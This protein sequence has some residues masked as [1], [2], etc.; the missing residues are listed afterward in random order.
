M[1]LVIMGHRAAP[2]LLQGKARLRPVERLD[3]TFFINGKD[4][5]MGRRRDVEPDDIVQFLGK[6]LVI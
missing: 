2:T 5:G 1:A 3:L 4:N 6:S